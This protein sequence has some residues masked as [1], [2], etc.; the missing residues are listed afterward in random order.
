MAS[1]VVV[2]HFGMAYVNIPGHQTPNKQWISM[3][4]ITTHIQDACPCKMYMCS[5]SVH[6]VPNMYA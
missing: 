3:K 5:L 6:R 1:I 4:C 2:A